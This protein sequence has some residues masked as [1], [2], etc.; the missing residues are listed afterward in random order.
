[1]PPSICKIEIQGFRAFGK[2]SQSLA[3]SGPIAAV[4]APNSQGKTSLAEAF[5]FLLTGQIVRRQLMASTQDEFADALRNAHMP[6]AMPVYVEADIVAADG[7]PH[8]LKRTLVSD[9][10]KRQDCQSALEIDGVVAGD[11]DLAS[12]GIVLSQPPLAAPVLAQHTLGYLFSARPQDRATYFKT[13]LEVTDL[14]ELRNAVATVTAEFK[15][16]EDDNWTKLSTASEIAEAKAFLIPLLTTVPD[17]AGLAGAL[18]NAITAILT[19]AGADVPAAQAERVTALETLLSERR[20]KTFPVDA[21]QRKTLAEWAVAAQA[22]WD[23]IDDYLAERAKLDEETRRL[24]ALFAEALAIPALDSATQ[25]IDCMLCGTEGSLTPQRIAFIREKLKE[26]EAFKN[27]ERAVLETLRRLTAKTQALESAV[28]GSCPKFLK[29]TS[30][31]RRES[32]FRVERI[33]SLLAEDETAGAAITQWLEKL[34]ALARAKSVVQKQLNALAAEIAGYVTKPESLHDPDSIKSRFD[35]AATAYNAFSGA[36]DAYGAAEQALA[37][38]LTAVIDAAS[39]TKGWQN[40][41]DL[42]RDPDALRESLIERHARDALQKELTQTVRRI[43]NGNAKVLDDK[44][45]ELSAGIQHWWD[46]L[47]PGEPTFFSAVAPR[48]GAR[49]TIDFKAG[50]SLRADRSA[51]KL[52]DVIAVFSQSQLHCLGLALFLA[53]SLHEGSGFLILDDPILASDEDY[54]A[55]FKSA[56]VESLL[57]AGVQVIILTQ[58]QK[59]WKD[60]EHRYL[61]KSI[62]MF[63]MA[64]VDPADGTSVANTGD[65]LMAMLVRIEVLA[66]G[67]H[68]DLH[69]QA[70][71]QLRNAAERFCKEMLVRDQWAKGNSH[72][73]IS[74]Y[75]GKNLGDLGPKVEPMLTADPSHPGKLRSIGNQLNPAKHDDGIP[76]QGTLR[77]AL[78][79]LRSL[80][81]QYLSP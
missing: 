49:R 69:K 70:G 10:A 35:A 57:D 78:G 48:K 79:D 4:W 25:A 30:A 19:A 58:D 6:A 33:R 50:L 71:E 63:Q 9:Y 5:E 74:D 43:D 36:L 66:R 76:P 22:D 23:K 47:R 45:T 39:D 13:I 16:E 44:F 51:P 41:I 7:N 27:A 73:A 53:R 11:A 21:F 32:G 62:D 77:V 46:L 8:T 34:L 2:N 29:A 1:M 60:L 12:L 67:G 72:S 38:M 68:T 37:D 42:V 40:L 54:R 81:K 65:D 61:H 24:T 75:D 15:P 17:K 64:L 20:A 18:D 28:L 56:A 14:E 52:R 26:A 3:F 31:A 80:K 55:Y 59:T